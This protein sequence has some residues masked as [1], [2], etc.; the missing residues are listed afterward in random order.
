MGRDDDGTGNGERK[1]GVWFEVEVGGE[2]TREYEQDG[3]VSGD[4]SSWVEGEGGGRGE[5]MDQNEICG[6]NREG[7]G[8]GVDK[9]EE[10]RCAA[11][12]PLLLL[13]LELR[14]G[15]RNR[16]SALRKV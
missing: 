14:G 3:F 12:L 10:V 15:K 7:W 6:H 8:G 1:K 16:K 9:K 11:V 2:R 4:G 13:A 5:K